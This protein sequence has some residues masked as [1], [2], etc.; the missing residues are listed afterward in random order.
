MRVMLFL[1]KALRSLHS[2]GFAHCDVKPGNIMYKKS[3]PDS[4]HEMNQV[5]LR[6]PKKKK[7]NP[8]IEPPNG[9]VELNKEVPIKIEEPEQGKFNH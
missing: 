2:K 7:K 5:K 9:R 4:S 6:K 1:I 8:E 3:G